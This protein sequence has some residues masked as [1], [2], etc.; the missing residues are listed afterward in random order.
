MTK[1]ITSPTTTKL[2]ACKPL[3]T[4]PPEPTI[5]VPEH[6]LTALQEMY[7]REIGSYQTL[8]QIAK[9]RGRH[10]STVSEA[11]KELSRRGYCQKQWAA[12]AAPYA[13]T[14]TGLAVVMRL[15]GGSDGYR[16]PTR[17]H[18]LIL[19]ADIVAQPSLETLKQ[20]FPGELGAYLLNVTPRISANVQVNK[21]PVKW[22]LNKNVAQFY[23]Q[24]NLVGT[25]VECMMLGFDLAAQA[26]AQLG[27]LGVEL[28]S[29]LRFER[30]P[31]FAYP[32]HPASLKAV[33]QGLERGR[34][35]AHHIWVDRSQGVPELETDCRRVAYLI[36]TTPF[37]PLDE[38]SSWMKDLVTIAGYLP[39]ASSL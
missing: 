21:I 10:I 9:K 3:T 8:G 6:K 24:Q 22:V 15:I 16:P 1:Q 19:Q 12:K 7:L 27:D 32:F 25:P 39:S 2:Q 20:R 38:V 36:E 34:S 31:E 18:A 35:P 14:N 26:A 29:Q 13:L 23:I 30:L 28:S 37:T 33:E 11:I 4:T 5:W 17:C